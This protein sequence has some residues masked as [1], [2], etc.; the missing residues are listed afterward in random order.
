MFSY[1]FW[2]LQQINKN[3]VVLRVKIFWLKHTI[4]LTDGAF[5]PQ[6]LGI[7]VFEQPRLKC[8]QAADG[9]G[10][11]NF[12]S[13]WLEAAD[14]AWAAKS[15]VISALTHFVWTLT[16]V[17]PRSLCV[18]VAFWRISCVCLHFFQ[19]VQRAGVPLMMHSRLSAS[20]CTQRP[21]CPSTCAVGS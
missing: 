17:S 14:K 13:Q 4:K 21:L 8:V 20:F 5:E 12:S 18:L 19:T 10:Q 7:L 6:M 16:T 2:V 3:K 9:E 11:W 1:F 15:L